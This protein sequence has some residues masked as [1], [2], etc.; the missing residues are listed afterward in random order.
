MNVYPPEKSRTTQ[1][2]TH[3]EF[4][5]FDGNNKKIIRGAES[6]KPGTHHTFITEVHLY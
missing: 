5:Y 1:N 4:Y 3:N 2:I 6:A